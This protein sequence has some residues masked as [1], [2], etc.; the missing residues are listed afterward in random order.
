[1]QATQKTVTT[2]TTQNE[3]PAEVREAIRKTLL[4]YVGSTRL[5]KLQRPLCAALAPLWP[6]PTQPSKAEV[7]HELTARYGPL[8]KTAPDRAE[9]ERLKTC[10]TCQSTGDGMPCAYPTETAK[11]LRAEVERLTYRHAE[12]GWWSPETV[13]AYEAEHADLR[14][15]LAAA[16]ETLEKARSVAYAAPELNMCNYDHEQVS[17][18]NVAMCEVF[19]LLDA[20]RKKDSK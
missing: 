14:T 2:T 13:K 17:K 9:V 3:L 6:K 19:T 11:A 7:I 20:A 18:L 12:A 10:P 4:D 1:M 5:L 16:Q 15:Q 8:E